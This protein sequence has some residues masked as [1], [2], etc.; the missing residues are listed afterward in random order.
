MKWFLPKAKKVA[1]PEL[2]IS[3]LTVQK[4]ISSARQDQEEALELI[5]NLDEHE[6]LEQS[7]KL[8][9]LKNCGSAQQRQLSA[10]I[11]SHLFSKHPSFHQAAI[12]LLKEHLKRPGRKVVIQQLMES[13]EN[14]QLLAIELS[15]EWNSRVYGEFIEVG[16]QSESTVVVQK[17]VEALSQIGLSSWSNAFLPLLDTGNDEVRL[18]VA[19]SFGQQQSLKVPKKV[20]HALLSDALN[21]VRMMGLRCIRARLSP[22]WIPHLLHHIDGSLHEE[23]HI[24]RELPEEEVCEVFKILGETEHPDAIPP[25]FE[26]LATAEN[27]GLRWAALQALDRIPQQHRIQFF[28]TRLKSSEKSELPLVFELIGYCSGL[29]AYELLKEALDT[30]PEPE[31]Q[32]LIASAMGT[33]GH[34]ACEQDLL[35][36][37]D[38]D[39]AVA[40]SAASALKSLMKGRV[41]KHFEVYLKRDNIDNLVKQILLQHVSESASTVD[42]DESLRET[43]D[44]LLRHDNE[45]IRYLSILALGAI[46]SPNSLRALI[47]IVEDDWTQLFRLELFNAIEDCCRG[48]ITPLLELMIDSTPSQRLILFRLAKSHPLI[49]T[50][51]DLDILCSND[52]FKAWNWD[53]ELL[54]CVEKTHKKDPFFVWRQFNRKNLDDRLCCFL[55]RGFHESTPSANDIIDPKVLINCFNRFQTEKPLLLLGK[56]MSNFPRSEFLPPLIQYSENA[57]PEVQMIFKSYVHKIVISMANLSSQN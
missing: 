34:E 30:H 37:M 10:I 12:D 14:E 17:T 42:V 22:S 7:E 54:P 19:Q 8:A 1:G 31:L 44:G 9:I 23:N 11:Q 57:D 32:S 35:K 20:I 40:Y 18:T 45:N 26:Q 38:G 28:K 4:L 13:G 51:T 55:A 56:L 53:E 21:T 46:G 29:A 49:I 43:I 50:D 33:S 52:A 48:S 2:S 39:V 3:E 25:L 5:L 6:E 15:K 27:Q 16:L 24:P 36:L 47:N 41:M